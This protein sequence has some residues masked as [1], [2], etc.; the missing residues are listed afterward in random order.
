MQQQTT[1]QQFKIQQQSVV[2][3]EPVTPV[4]PG[5]MTPTVITHQLPVSAQATP[6]T[7]P[8]S[9]VAA[10]GSDVD[11]VPTDA[12]DF[13][14]W[15]KHKAAT[16]KVNKL[17]KRRRQ[18][19]RF[20]KLLIP[21]NAIMV[22]NELQPGISFEADEQMN[23]FS[24]L[25]YTVKINVDGATYTGEGSSKAAAK[26]AAAEL[27]VKGLILKKIT[28]SGIKRAT[29]ASAE[30]V[31]EDMDTASGD[32][33]SEKGSIN[34]RRPI[35]EDEVPWGSLASFALFKLFADWKAQGTN[36]P[37]SISSPQ[38]T[39]KPIPKVAGSKP[40]TAPMKGN[41]PD[42]PETLHPVTLVGRLYPG[43]LF[44][45]IS[46][47]GHAPHLTFCIGATVNGVQYTGT[48]RNKKEAK[49]NC[50]IEILKAANIPYN[51]SV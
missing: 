32:D 9:Q 13:K 27:A 6:Q 12:A 38:L 18:N 30:A 20:R 35:P 7:Q 5:P 44:S 23:A 24:Q 36:I 47:E 11:T 33:V 40:A 41:I 21:K 37:P 51:V 8:Q 46:R 26:A 45:E 17:L 15:K 43:T 39:P 48:A 2:K 29:S 16:F 42:N 25:V 31:E 22:L 10:G 19:A 50:A 4:K 28:E 1:P 34:G 49:K 14:P 3:T